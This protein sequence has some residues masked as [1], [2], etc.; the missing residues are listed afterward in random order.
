MRRH[1]RPQRREV[2]S[3]A[4]GPPL[5]PRDRRDEQRA[6][7]AAARVDK[8][9]RGREAPRLHCRGARVPRHHQ[10]GRAEG[11]SRR[12]DGRADGHRV[13]NRPRASYRAGEI[14]H[15]VHPARP[16]RVRGR[17]AGDARVQEHRGQRQGDHGRGDDHSRVGVG[18]RSPPRLFDGHHGLRLQPR[19]GR[20]AVVADA[21]ADDAKRFPSAAR[22]LHRL[23]TSI[24]GRS[25]GLD[26]RARRGGHG[27]RHFR[28][29]LPRRRCL[30]RGS[31]QAPHRVRR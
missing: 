21:S 15:G 2:W 22:V 17:D 16:E 6:K 28:P 5:H 18:D 24:L 31:K 9:H 27:E 20:P 14:L 23:P 7:A 3:A 11:I 12:K 8:R 1:G 10:P 30:A 29:G 19:P 25:R 4:Q 13:E 26:P